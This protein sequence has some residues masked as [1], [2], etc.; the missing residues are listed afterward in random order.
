MSRRWRH[1]PPAPP[2]DVVTDLKQ[3]VANDADALHLMSLGAGTLMDPSGLLGPLPLP[4]G[5]RMSASGIRSFPIAMS[6]AVAKGISLKGAILVFARAN[7]PPVVLGHAP[8]GT[9]EA[10]ARA[11]ERLSGLPFL[12]G[13]LAWSTLILD[14]QTVALIS[15]EHAVDYARQAATRGKP[16]AKVGSPRGEWMPL[17]ALNEALVSHLVATWPAQGGLDDLRTD[18]G[19]LDPDLLVGMA[20]HALE[21]VSVSF[22]SSGDGALHVEISQVC[23]A[24]AEAAVEAAYRS[25]GSRSDPKWRAI[26]ER[27]VLRPEANRRLRVF[28]RI[29]SEEQTTILF[30]L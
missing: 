4:L 30:G 3:W 11:T 23:V 29:S 13:D 1:L 14:D 2:K 26:I 12:P 5:T 28:F 27:A 15:R 20:E 8:A 22:R 9:K 17:G 6:V 16:K 7:G 19:T 24:G 21:S 18:D 10:A 25:A